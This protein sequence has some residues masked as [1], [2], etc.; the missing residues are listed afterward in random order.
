MHRRRTTQRPFRHQWWGGGLTHAA[1]V[2]PSRGAAYE[3]TPVCPPPDCCGS[4]RRATSVQ[5]LLGGRQRCDE[6]CHIRQQWVLYIWRETGAARNGCLRRMSTQPNAVQAA[7]ATT[8]L[9]G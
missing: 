2:W 5:Q 9:H 8:V 7:T 6:R 4:R 3:A 1:E